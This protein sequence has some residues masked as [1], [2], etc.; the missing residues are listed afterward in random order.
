ML[1]QGTMMNTKATTADVIKKREVRLIKIAQRELQ[2]DDVTYRAMLWSHAKVKSA[3]ELDARGRKK[4]LD[5]FKACGFQV[6][7][8]PQNRNVNDP[9]YR[10]IRAIW[11]KL[12]ECGLVE[13][14]TDHAIRSYIKRQTKLDDFQFLNK[15][16]IITVIESLKAWLARGDTIEEKDSDV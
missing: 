14:N 1:T 6:K 10:K 16:Q 15:F 12:H 9:R 8:Q 13:H 3:T 5:H 4:V 7:L 2:M 11:N